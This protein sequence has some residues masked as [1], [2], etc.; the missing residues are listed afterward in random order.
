MNAKPRLSSK[1]KKYNALFSDML[2]KTKLQKSVREC[3]GAKKLLFKN[4][5]DA[6]NFAVKGDIKK[7]IASWQTGQSELKKIKAIV[8]SYTHIQT[9]YAN[10]IKNSDDAAKKLINDQIKRIVKADD[11]ATKHS[12]AVMAKINKTNK[13]DE[14]DITKKV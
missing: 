7:G 5:K 10:E 12:E 9:K 6:Q 3:A 13:T 4:T 2:V 8:K 14:S 1:T 11:E